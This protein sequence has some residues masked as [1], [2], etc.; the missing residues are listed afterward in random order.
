VA[1]R[2]EVDAHVGGV[3]ARLP[4]AVA[5]KKLRSANTAFGFVNDVAG[6]AR[7][8]ALRRVEVATPMGKASIAAPPVV[9]SDGD[10]VLGHVPAIGE[11][12]AA[13]REEFGVSRRTL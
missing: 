2:E 7:H 1:R 12:T 11:H 5:A 9:A 3:F 4:A 13:I 8:P 10:A 6:L